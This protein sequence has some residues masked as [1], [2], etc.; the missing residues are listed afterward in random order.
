MEDETEPPESLL[1]YAAWT[2]EALRHVMVRALQYVSANGLPGGHHFYLTFRTDFPG[3]SPPATVPQAGTL[4]V[5]GT[6]TTKTIP[7]NGGYLSVSGT[8]NTIT[9]TGHCTSVSVA[10]HGNQVTIDNTD[11]ISASGTNNLVTYH[12]GSPKIAN[13]GTSNTVLQG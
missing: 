12:W 7:C 2:E 1:P 4:Q 5:S 8:T 6:G 9:I 11:A 13:A 10:G 3:S